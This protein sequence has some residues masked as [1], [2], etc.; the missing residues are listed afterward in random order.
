MVFPNVFPSS[1]GPTLMVRGSFGEVRLATARK[2]P[3][4]DV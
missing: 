1:F 2:I 3:H 4:F